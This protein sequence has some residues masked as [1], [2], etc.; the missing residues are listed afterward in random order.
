MRILILISCI[1]FATFCPAQNILLNGGFEAGMTNWSFWFDTANGYTGN[2]ALETSNPY[3]GANCG[4][5]VVSSI[6]AAAEHPRV[7]V[8][9]HMFGLEA[10]KTYTVSVYLR[11]SGVGKTF[12]M[13]VHQDGSPYTS[14]ATQT[15]TTTNSWQQ[16]S[17]VF[18]SPVTTS[19]VRFA[20]NLG[21]SIGEYYFDEAV[22][23]KQGYP[24]VIDPDYSVDWSQAGRPGGIPDIPNTLNVMNFGAV[25]DGSTDN[26]AA[27]QNTINAAGIGQ[28][29]FVPAG[30]YRINGTINLPEGVVIRGDCPTTTHL[31]FDNS[32]AALSCID[33]IANSYGNFQQVTAGLTKGSTQFTI[34]NT[35][36]FS[37]GDYAEILQE[38][39][40]TLMY[41]DT[42]WI[43]SWSEQAVGQ[44]FVVTAVNNNQITVDRPLNIDLNPAL[45]PRLRTIELVEDVGIENLYIER[46]DAG[47]GSTIRFKNAARCWVRNIESNMTYRSHVSMDRV[48]D[49]EIVN[50]YF[51]HSHDYGGGGH[52][53]GVGMFR[54]STSNLVENN[55]FEHLRHS[56]MIHLGANGNVLGYNYSSQAHWPW[57]GFPAD[58]SMHGH[59]SF[60]NLFEGNIV[61]YADF[62]DYWGPSG[63]G[64]TLF[65]NRV[66]RGD[67]KVM[68]HSHNSNVIANELTQST[69]NIVVDPSV[70]DTWKHSNTVNG[71]IDAT[72]TAS[73]PPSLYKLTK[74]DFLFGHSYPAF[75]PDVPLGANTI[76]AKARYDNGTPMLLC[77]CNP[78]GIDCYPQGTIEVALKLYPEGAYD[79]TS[80][81]LTTGLFNK[82]LLPG[83]TPN[84]N[85]TATPAG[86]PYADAPWNYSGIEGQFFNDYDY[87]HLELDG[88]TPVDWVLVDFRSATTA[89]S[90]VGQT[91]GILL[92]DGSVRLLNAAAFFNGFPSSVYIKVEHRNHLP[93]MTAMPVSLMNGL[94]SHDFTTANSYAIS[95][96]GSK[97]LIAGIWAMYAGNCEQDQDLNGYDINGLDNKA[98]TADNGKF[99]I[100]LGADM[101]LDGEVSAA[102]KI[103]WSA[104]N[105]FFSMLD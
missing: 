72:T 69:A 77:H 91:T 58:I 73:L 19:D 83:Q 34:A 103:L 62:A 1:C 89:A 90:S 60:M 64:N 55:I 75:G 101:N 30:T 18:T 97:E 86:H 46:L 41:T 9:N 68:D 4:K 52:G 61:E 45:N 63:P 8:R 3:S 26:L 17:L 99:S 96:A 28:A 79:G 82:G 22:I 40:A 65:R 67:I 25:G 32:G 35:N 93:V 66:N 88:P 85:G 95:G 33:I 76:D 74:P 49:T 53:Y 2:Q 47:D 14:Y 48:I 50:N 98:W 56:M 87:L 23:T 43:Q 5:V 105:G 24:V 51:H 6:G 100:Y 71:V 57:S 92:S 37:V 102:D 38:N 84:G 29:V 78:Q 36:S 104:N 94:L 20:L 81:Q 16:Y 7:L 39:D 59:Y 21:G 15:F 31:L 10:G 42:T 27:F 70:N 12:K 13:R 80:G 54:H 44:L 11:S